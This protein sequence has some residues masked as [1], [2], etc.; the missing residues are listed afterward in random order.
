M[1]RCVLLASA[2]ALALAAGGCKGRAGSSDAAA[3]STPPAAVLVEPPVPAKPAAPFSFRQSTPDAEVSLKLARDIGRWPGLH[4]EAFARGSADLRAFQA[5]AAS[6]RKA[7]PS[8]QGPPYARDLE[9]ALSAATQRLVSLRQSWYENQGGA[10]P[11]RGYDSYLWDVAANRSI[12]SAALFKPPGGDEAGVQKALCDGID[13]AKITRGV[14]WDPEA[15]PCPKWREVRF[16]LA[17]STVPGKVG[18]LVFLFDPD[19]VGAYAE[20]EYEVTLSQALFTS[21]FAP[22]YAAEFA[23]GPAPHPVA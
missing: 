4:R 14:A 6:D 10:H 5:S 19:T 16:V 20:G 17:P 11:N 12:G 9:L 8:G 3:A 7:D 1:R 2:M 13:K 22:D 18:A 21:L 15:Y 23:G